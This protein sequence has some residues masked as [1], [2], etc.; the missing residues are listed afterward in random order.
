M[1][2][3]KGVVGSLWVEPVVVPGLPPAGTLRPGDHG[4][5]ESGSLSAEGRQPTRGESL[6]W[7][8]PDLLRKVPAAVRTVFSVTG[9]T[10]RW[11]GVAVASLRV[12]QEVRTWPFGGLPGSVG[13]RCAG[14]L[15][16]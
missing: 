3:Q 11:E 16:C 7:D 12:S 14:G 15:A 9:G 10:E 4:P 6:P 5:L 1:R 13:K 2:S 8:L